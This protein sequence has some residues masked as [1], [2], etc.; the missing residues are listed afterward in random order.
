M[1]HAH[2]HETL[3]PS[4]PHG[5][6]TSPSR[7]LPKIETLATIRRSRPWSS[8]SSRRRRTGVLEALTRRTAELHLESGLRHRQSSTP[9]LQPR[10][11][12]PVFVVFRDQ[13]PRPQ[14]PIA[15]SLPWRPKNR[16]GTKVISIHQYQEDSIYNFLFV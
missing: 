6:T 13:G 1:A 5:L 4:D 9:A 3:T 15:S 8:S 2:L 10:R 12:V 7:P 16:M 11:P 14:L